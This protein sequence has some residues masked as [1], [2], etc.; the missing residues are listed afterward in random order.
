MTIIGSVT[1]SAVSTIANPQSGS[2]NAGAFVARAGTIKLGFFPTLSEAKRSVNGVGAGL[3][4]WTQENMRSGVEHWVAR[5]TRLD[6]LD[7]AGA[8]LKQW[9]DIDANA[10]VLDVSTNKVDLLGDR[11]DNRRN[12]TQS[13]PDLQGLYVANAANGYAGLLL[14]GHR[15]T[16]EL[17]L[18]PPFTVILAVNFISSFV[19]TGSTILSSDGDNNWRIGVSAA[20]IWE[21]ENSVGTTISGGAA[22]TTIDLLTVR[23]GTTWGEFRVNRAIV[24]GNGNYTS[25]GTTVSLGAGTSTPSISL[26]WKGLL[27]SLSIFDTISLSVV[28][29]AERVVRERYNT[30]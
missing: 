25:S 30:P 10:R 15:M 19:D 23:Q 9:C 20:G 4:R 11:S 28:E 14:D 22:D 21:Y 5:D 3:L 26:S 6:L 13:D 16:S 18:E 29:Q 2:S 1:R 7:I 17:P 8:N 12:Y 24:G 27:A